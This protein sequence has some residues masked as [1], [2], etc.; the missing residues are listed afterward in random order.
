MF[1]SP[2]AKFEQFCVELGAEKP[3]FVFDASYLLV[4]RLLQLCIPS[5]EYPRSDLPD[6]FRFAGGLP[7]GH[8]PPYTNTPF[9][10][11]EIVENKT[12]KVIFV[13]QGTVAN[14]FQQLVIPTM[15]AFADREDFLVVVALGGKGLSLP[16]TIPIP[17]NARVA[18]FIPYDEILEYTDVFV[19]N[20]GYGALQ[21]AVSHG[22]PLVIGGLSEDKPEVAARAEYAGIGINLRTATPELE[23]LRNAVD[24]ILS[25]PRFNARA[26]ELEAEK[27]SY[28]PMKIIAATIDE[29][30][31]KGTV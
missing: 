10:W 8:R 5:L 7:K 27:A 2:Q 9:W 23:Q 16:D 17:S 31:A 1:S 21:H 19:S 18:D 15:N 25:N 4:D 14:K 12:K 24:E 28:D 30:A 20:G 26:L 22:T 6:N 29:L 13:C 3:P 11:N